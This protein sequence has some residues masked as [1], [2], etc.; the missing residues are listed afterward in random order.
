MPLPSSIDFDRLIAIALYEI[1]SAVRSWVSGEPREEGA[2]LNHITGNLRRR[3][4]SCDVGNTA[5]VR[6]E[7]QLSVLHRKGP[8]QTDRFGC[9]LAVT[10]SIPADGFMKTAFFQIKKSIEYEA[11]I[12]HRQ[13]IDASVITAIQDRAFVLVADEVRHGIRL[14][15]VSAVIQEIPPSQATK[16]FNCANWDTIAQWTQAWLSCS[17]GPESDPNDPDRV[18]KLLKRYQIQPPLF[19]GEEELHLLGDEEVVPA[20]AWLEL[21]FV[22]GWR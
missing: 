6:M 17:I 3:R 9:D 16:S 1:H 11:S 21:A 10:V 13:L 15:A 22:E 7:S 5:P 14:N 18:E 4:R 12:E 20:R 8:R 2:L 19:R